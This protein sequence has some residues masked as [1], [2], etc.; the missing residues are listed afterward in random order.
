MD[1]RT[2]SSRYWKGCYFITSFKSQRKHGGLLVVIQD[3]VIQ[4]NFI[5]KVVI[6]STSVP[7]SMK[8]HYPYFR[9]DPPLFRQVSSYYSRFLSIFCVYSVICHHGLVSN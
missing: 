7:I 3:V 9:K 6:D 1:V 5:S 2:A 8:L 4:D